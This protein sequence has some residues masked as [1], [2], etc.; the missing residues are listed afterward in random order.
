M[1]L[2][3]FEKVEDHWRV[4]PQL[5]QEVRWARVNLAGDLSRMG[6]FDV[7]L[8]RNVLSGFTREAADAALANLEGALAPDGCLVLGADES[9]LSLPAAFSGTG[10]LHL[11]DPAFRRDAA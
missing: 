9:R 7:I 6:P 8:C 3:H 4:S 10:G 2:S 1:L 11:R 5:R